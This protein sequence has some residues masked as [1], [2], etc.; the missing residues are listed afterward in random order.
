MDRA[1]SAAVGRER[2]VHCYIRFHGET[3]T[4][5]HCSNPITTPTQPFQLPYSSST[6]CGEFVQTPS[7]QAVTSN[8]EPSACRFE[9][10][11]Q[12]LERLKSTR[13]S[14]RRL[15]I[16]TKSNT[17]KAVGLQLLTFE[18]T[19]HANPL[20]H[21]HKLSPSPGPCRGGREWCGELR[22]A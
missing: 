12:K 2:L 14:L 13:G 6:S 18:S 7:T 3:V 17:G 21:A 8:L 15:E 9:T 4:C 5:S 1:G 16:T 11:F 19:P 20:T 10:C 22:S